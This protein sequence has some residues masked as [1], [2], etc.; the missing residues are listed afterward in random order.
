MDPQFQ[1]VVINLLDLEAFKSRIVEQ[2]FRAMPDRGTDSPD[3]N[4]R[5][6]RRD[7]RGQCFQRRW[8]DCVTG[9]GQ[10]QPHQEKH[11]DAASTNAF[12]RNQSDERGYHYANNPVATDPLV[13]I[14]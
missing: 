7:R 3:G 4:I 9:I 6:T 5:T 1:C 12:S 11:Q 10:S 14:G 8:V 2:D 13:T